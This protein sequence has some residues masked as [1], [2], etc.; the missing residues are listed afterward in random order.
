MKSW[1][2]INEKIKE[3]SNSKSPLRCLTQLFE[4]TGDGM[5]ALG[6]GEEYEKLGDPENAAIYYTEAYHRFPKIEWKNTA[7]QKLDNLKIRSQY[8]MNA[9]ILYVISCA[10]RKHSGGCDAISENNRSGELCTLYRVSC[11]VPPYKGG[12][13]YP[14][15][16]LCKSLQGCKCQ[17]GN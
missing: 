16:I 10:K 12:Y 5:V 17:K 6:L 3:C 15:L 8:S 4:Q 7:K 11:A 14:A 1:Y 9:S 2:S 13:K